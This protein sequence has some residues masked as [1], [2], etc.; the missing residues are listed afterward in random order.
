MKKAFL[1][2]FVLIGLSILL[3]GCCQ[4]NL[5]NQN[6]PAANQNEKTNENTNKSAESG[7]SEKEKTELL[8]ELTEADSIEECKSISEQ[9]VNSEPDCS[10]IE[11]SEHGFLYRYSMIECITNIAIRQDDHA[12]CSDQKTIEDICLKW[13]ELSGFPVEEPDPE[14]VKYIEEECLLAFL[15]KAEPDTT[16]TFNCDSFEEERDMCY[17]YMATAKMDPSI[18]LNISDYGVEDCMHYFAFRNHD[19]GLCEH[20][21]DWRIEQCKEALDILN[22]NDVSVCEDTDFFY[23]SSAKDGCYVRFAIFNKDSSICPKDEDT[24][25][26][27]DFCER[28]AK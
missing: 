12:L 16:I 24:G 13:D 14:I 18:C 28:Y 26:I 8:T 15:L 1:F 4:Q 3:A 7:L 11:C 10:G 19:V 5:I 6:Q 2:S 20:G 21:R 27:D 17:E 23:G 9:I 22:N 25:Y